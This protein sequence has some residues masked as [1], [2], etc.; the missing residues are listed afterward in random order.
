V[1]LA[2]LDR[3]CKVKAARTT[4]VSP[5]FLS[6]RSAFPYRTSFLIDA[7]IDINV[8]VDETAQR[9]PPQVIRPSGSPKPDR[10]GQSGENTSGK[11]PKNTARQESNRSRYARLAD[12]PIKTRLLLLR[13]LDLTEIVLHDQNTVPL[14]K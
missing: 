7:T 9:R 8:Q 3:S 10:E 12:D 6:M 13:V 2:R 4:K 14:G 1:H 11:P 5:D